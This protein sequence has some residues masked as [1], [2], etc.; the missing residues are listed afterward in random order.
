MT[1][2]PLR[3]A[4]IGTARRSSY[5]YAPLLQAMPDLQL[6]GI[7]GRSEP[8]A[9]RLGTA[10]GV[11]HYTDMQRLMDEAAPQIGIVSV[12]YGANGQVGLAAVEAGMHVLLET[13]I[14]HDLAEADAIIAAAERRGVWIEV[15]EQFHRRPLEQIKLRLIASGLFGRVHSAFNDFGGHGYHGIS[16]MRSYLGFDARPVRVSGAVHTYGL[17]PYYSRIAGDHGARNETQEHGLIEFD[18]GRIGI[19]HWT[20]VGYDSPLRWWRSSRFLAERGMGITIGVG[21]DVE[22]RLSLLA[23]G[24][25]APQFITIERRWERVDGGALVAIVAHTGTA[26]Q[27]IVTWNNPFVP[28][29][30]GHGPQWHDDEIGVAGCIRSLVDAVNSNTPPSYG[31]QQGRLDQELI[32]A[33]RRS[34]ATGGSPVELPLR[35]P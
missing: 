13:P 18:D 23:P 32:L 28:R 35:E 15:A 25:E 26:E 11:P 14:A 31:P 29:I 12:N 33:I 34:A 20:S 19:F 9:S 3:V 16:V 21:L 17:A 6:V 24:G 5:L 2:Q 27:P 8:S 10:L 22:E 1:D 4:I 30:Q 7:W